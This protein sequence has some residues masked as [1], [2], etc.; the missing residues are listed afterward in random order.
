MQSLWAFVSETVIARWAAVV[1]RLARSLRRPSYDF[2]HILLRAIKPRKFLFPIHIR[3]F[4]YSIPEINVP[5][6]PPAGSPTI[7]EQPPSTI[8]LS[9]IREILWPPLL[10]DSSTVQYSAE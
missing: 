6:P 1:A 10:L 9:H 5:P 8:D 7:R 3:I 2:H 4:L